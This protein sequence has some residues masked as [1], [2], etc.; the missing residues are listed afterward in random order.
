MAV[1]LQHETLQQVGRI[2]L[3]LGQGQLQLRVEQQQQ[4]EHVQPVQ[5]LLPLV[6]LVLLMLVH[7]CLITMVVH[8]HTCMRH[9][10]YTS[11]V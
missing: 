8:A 11:L 10:C 5:P 2:P 1:E 7:A 9:L 4:R 3:P 6:L